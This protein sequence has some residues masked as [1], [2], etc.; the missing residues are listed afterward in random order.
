MI[1]GFKVAAPLFSGFMVG[2]PNRMGSILA[3]VNRELLEKSAA[4]MNIRKPSQVGNDP[5]SV[6]FATSARAKCALIVLPMISRD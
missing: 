6:G 4:G 2:T 3:G 5:T 1:L